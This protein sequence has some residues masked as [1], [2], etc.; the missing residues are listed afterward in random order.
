MI[1]SGQITV[2]AGTA[3]DDPEIVRLPVTQGIITQLDIMFPPGCVNEVFI[4]INRGLHQIYPT[5]PDGFFTGDADKISGAV[6]HHVKVDPFEVEIFG[7]S[8]D[9]DYNHTIT[10]LLWIKKA[11]QLNPLSDEF[12]RLSLIDSGEVP[13]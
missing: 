5:N 8:P 11:W 3:K 10:F 7:W 1:F 6:F 9:A 13:P 12:W 2:P 4:T